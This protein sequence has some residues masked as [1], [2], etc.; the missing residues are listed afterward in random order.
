MS[1]FNVTQRPASRH[2]RIAFYSPRPA[3]LTITLAGYIPLIVN[4]L[5][6]IMATT[7]V[8]F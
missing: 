2:P 7:S 5:V 3:P 1:R 4:S 8:P 6:A